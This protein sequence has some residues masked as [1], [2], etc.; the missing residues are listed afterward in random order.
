MISFN[1]RCENR[2]EFEGWFKNSGEFEAQAGRSLVECPYCGSRTIEKA[3]MAPAISSGRPASEQPVSVVMEPEQAEMMSQL[4]ALMQKV[5]ENAEYVGERFAEEARRIHYGETE[6]RGIYGKAS[7]AEV[8]SLAEE[9]VEFMP[10]PTLP[11]DR[12]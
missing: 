7:M 1:L 5:R 4:R 6:A 10:L 3:L 2:H 8:K 9:G 12:N 11:E